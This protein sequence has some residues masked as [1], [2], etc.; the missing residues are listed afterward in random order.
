ME[1]LPS[2]PQRFDP[3]EQHSVYH[4]FATS[5]QVA[6]TEGNPAELANPRRL[7]R[8]RTKKRFL[9]YD[10]RNS[11]EA[12]A[13]WKGKQNCQGGMWAE[14]LQATGLEPAPQAAPGGV[15][16]RHPARRPPGPTAAP[17][18]RSGPRQAARPPLRQKPPR[19][20]GEVSPGLAPRRPSAAPAPRPA[21]AR[22]PLPGG[23]GPAAGSPQPRPHRGPAHLH[24]FAEV[25]WPRH[26][27]RPGP[28]TAATPGAPASRPR[29]R[30]GAG[31]RGRLPSVRLSVAPAS[32]R[33]CLSG[34]RAGCS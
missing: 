34:T 24:L 27:Q 30:P 25:A 7:S 32:R 15:G 5:E 21:P 28:A 9:F 20:L 22:R 10:V 17:R 12:G 11:P 1:L 18:P 33:C 4:Q 6:K 31:S 3:S 23:G 2:R 13:I 29:R 19:A 26:R 8:R 14:D 16:R